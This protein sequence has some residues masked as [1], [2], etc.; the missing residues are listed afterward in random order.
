MLN[1]QA[2]IPARISQNRNLT[3]CIIQPVV[4]QPY[5][6]PPTGGEFGF[7][8]ALNGDSAE[9]VVGQ[10]LALPYVGGGENERL[11]MRDRIL[12]AVGI[13][14]V[15]SGNAAALARRPDRHA[16]DSGER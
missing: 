8:D 5:P 6:N 2:I 9:V 16:G 4:Y 11:A 13:R 7:A 10:R 1:I 14:Q 15:R 3:T 12:C